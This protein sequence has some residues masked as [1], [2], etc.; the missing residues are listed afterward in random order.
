MSEATRALG[1]LERGEAVH[2]D[3]RRDLLHGT[4]HRQVV[5][6]VEVGMDAALQAHLGGAA[7]DR[8]HHAPLDL[9]VVEEVRAAAEV[10]RQRTLGERAEPA[11]ERADV[12]VVDV[13]VAHEGDGVADGID[14]ELIGDRGDLEE[15]GTARAE[16][17]DDLVDADLVTCEHAVEHV[18]HRR[19]GARR[20]PRR[21]R[22]GQ[23]RGWRGV[24]ARG[25][26]V[27]ARQTFE[28][29]RAPHRRSARRRAATRRRGARTPDRR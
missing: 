9:L 12:R 26:R 21:D 11:L 25:P 24:A 10:Q 27:V 5:L 28:I 18:T 17:R 6:A 15:V 16:E 19:A 3:L 23:H 14:A 22:R 8:F 20:P 1:H 4:R 29:G 7:V 2:V 13:A